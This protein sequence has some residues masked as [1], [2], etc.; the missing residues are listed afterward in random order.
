M[1][2]KIVVLSFISLLSLTAV[3]GLFNN[4]FAITKADEEDEPAVLPIG[5]HT[6]NVL[7]VQDYIDMAVIEALLKTVNIF[8]MASKKR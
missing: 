4:N 6:I 1:K 5:S 2:K 7:N 3:S 8:S